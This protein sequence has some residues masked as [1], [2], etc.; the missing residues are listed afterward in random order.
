MLLSLAA[1]TAPGWHPHRATPASNPLPPVGKQLAQANMVPEL[2]LNRLTWGANFSTDLQLQAVGPDR[3]LDQQL[4]G[5]TAILPPAIQAQIDGMTISRVPFD[6]MM[7]ELEAQ[8]LAAESQKGTDDSLRKAYQQELTRL[9]RQAAS[10]ALLRDIYSPYQLQEQMTWFWMNHFN[11]HSGKHNVRAMLGDFEEHAIRPYALGN[12]RDLLRATVF[13]PAMLRYLDNEHNAANHINENYARELLELHTMGVNSGY[14]QHD[15]Q[16]LARILTGVGIRIAPDHPRMRP[17]LEKLYVRRGIF[18]FNPQ[19]HD[20]GDKLLLGNTVHGSGLNEIEQ[21][22]TLLCRQPATAR[23]ISRQL[24]TYFVSDTPPEA[25][26]ERMAA[27]FLQSDGNLQLTMHTLLSSPELL[28]SLGS[29]FKDPMH[30]L[31][32][33][34]RLAYDGN[35]IVNTAPL[36]NWLALMGQMP[37]AHQTPDGYSMLESA[38][39]SSGQMATRF[40]VANSLGHGS[41]ALF[42]TDTQPLPDKIPQPALSSAPYVRHWSAKMSHTTQQALQQTHSIADWNSLFLASPEMMR[43]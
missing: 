22:I 1:C 19:R 8:R 18:E 31:L 15:V 12:F 9:A 38:W 3:F 32:S 4:R 34:I 25:L 5:R 6:Q 26:V 35:T 28:A 10:R 14:S 21:V 29:K 20:F 43:R 11:I 39:S 27:T 2:F 37:N 40:D 41:P 33:S 17:A 23:H 30:Y 36:L 7:R 24:A 16:E 42:R 13:H